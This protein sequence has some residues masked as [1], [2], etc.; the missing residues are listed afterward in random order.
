MHTHNPVW[1]PDGQWIYFVHG[2]EPTG[3]MDVWRMRPSGE[4]PEQLTH[5][6]APVNF[7]VPL[8]S[9]TLLYVARAEDW[10]GPWLWALDVES[11]VTRRVTAGLEQY[12][13]RCRPAG[14]AVAWSRPWPI[15]RPASGAC[16]C[17][18]GSSRI[19]TRSPTPC[20]P[21]GPWRR[22]SAG[23]RCSICRSLPVGPATGSGA[24]QNEQ[25]FEV[26]KGADGVLFEPPA[27]SPD[28]SR[29]AV[30]V[31]QQ[32]KRHLAIMSADGTNSRTLAASIDIQ[33]V[34]GARHRRLVA[35]RHLD[36]HRWR[37]RAGAGFVQDPGR[38]RRARA[39]R[40]RVR[41]V[42]PVW[43]PNGDLIVYA[44][45]PFAGA[46]G[47]NAL[48][49]VRPDG[50]PVEMPEVRVRRGWSP[51]FPAA[52]VRAWSTCQGIES[53]DFWLRRSRHEQDPSA[54]R[55]QRSRLPESR[56]TSR[57]TGN[58]SCSTV[59]DRTPM[60]S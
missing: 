17:S 15:P 18:I 45:V 29:V 10:S 27:V 60:S 41:R 30:V 50:T 28:G 22:A 11:K 7:L 4:S 52:A 19:A 56:S 26:R 6:N 57:L 55:P 3:E 33:G 37:R 13:V 43:S 54:H 51:P 38:R 44:T 21:N 32:G 48:R 1:S 39:A 14:T 24:V 16:R 46:G 23:R 9:R 5:Q 40:R 35:R 42:N 34:G 2:P 49:G 8:D 25:A 58:T 36:R 12:H 31:R 47:R 53:K 59:R 20:Q